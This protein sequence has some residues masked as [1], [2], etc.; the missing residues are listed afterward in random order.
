MSCARVVLCISMVVR[1]HVGAIVGEAIEGGR[2]GT[3]QKSGKRKVV[4]RQYRFPRELSARA[5]VRLLNFPHVFWTPLIMVRY[6]LKTFIQ[7]TFSGCSH[8]PRWK[9][10]TRPNLKNRSVSLDMLC[11]SAERLGK[12]LSPL[13]ETTAVPVRR[14]Q[15]CSPNSFS[16]VRL[17]D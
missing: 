8:C 14:L 4:C 17:T 6:L 3:S 5:T 1:E 2:H 13:L 15:G 10:G 12:G 11:T 7:I 9:T 16:A